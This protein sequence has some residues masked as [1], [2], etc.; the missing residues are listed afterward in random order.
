M[1]F[2]SQLDTS[3]MQDDILYCRVVVFVRFR[4]LLIGFE[5]GTGTDHI[6]IGY[7]FGFE[8]ESFIYFGKHQDDI[9]IT[10][11]DPARTATSLGISQIYIFGRLPADVPFFLP[12]STTRRANR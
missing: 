7:G 10:K 8:S 3:L 6:Y 5:F 12:T 4:G 2:E 1:I 9:G 11:Y